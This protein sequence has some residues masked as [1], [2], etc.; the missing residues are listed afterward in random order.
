[1]FQPGP[2]WSGPPMAVLL[3]KTDLLS[4][5]QIQE[6]TDW[7]TQ[8]CRAEQVGDCVLQSACSTWSRACEGGV[9][10]HHQQVLCFHAAQ[11]VCAA[12]HRHHSAPR[13]ARAAADSLKCR[14]A[15]AAGVGGGGSGVCWQCA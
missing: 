1:M 10:C 11:L 3:N 4:E 2:D 9:F 6:L 12:Q 13:E 7:Y 14:T 15:A 5:E 8:N